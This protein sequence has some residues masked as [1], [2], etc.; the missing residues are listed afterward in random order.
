MRNADTPAMQKYLN[1][2]QFHQLVNMLENLIHQAQFTPS[3]LREAAVFAAIRYE[4]NRP[5]RPI[6]REHQ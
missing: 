4:M 3:E 6:M 1:D 2:P 5:V